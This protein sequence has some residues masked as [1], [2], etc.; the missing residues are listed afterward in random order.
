[1]RIKA[2]HVWIPAAI[3]YVLSFVMVIYEE[4]VIAVLL[5]VGYLSLL[6]CTR[7]TID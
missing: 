6:A 1:M 7:W 5:A 3:L 2:L 4:S